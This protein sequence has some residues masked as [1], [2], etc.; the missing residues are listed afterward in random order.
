MAGF[1]APVGLPDNVRERLSN[2]CR[3]I[4]LNGNRFRTVT[5]KLGQDVNYLGS[6]RWRARILEDSNENKPI[7][8]QLG[9]VR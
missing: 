5:A 6:E 2:T 4:A 7:I 9:T 3:D 1:Y 8:E